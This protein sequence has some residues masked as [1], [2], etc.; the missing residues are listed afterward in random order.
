MSG[1]GVGRPLTRTW[2][3]VLLIS[4]SGVFVR[5]ADT[6]PAR[7]AFL[8]GFYALPILV[9]GALFL[10][11][12]AGRPLRGAVVPLAILAGGLLGA[13]LVAWHTSIGIIGAGLATVLPNLQVVLVGILGILLFR[14][15][16][17]ATFWVAV[18]VV[19]VG[20]AILGV[21]GHALTADASVL[22]GVLFGLLTAVF[23]SGYLILLRLA[24]LGRPEAGAFDVM[25]SATL[26]ASVVAGAWA[27][28][29][30]VAAPPPGLASNLWL[31]A[32]AVGSQV[33]G[34]V[35]LS[36]SIHRLPAALTSV[37]LLLQPVL[38]LVWGAGL[39]GE[40]I[41]PVDVLGAL[42]I[43]GGVA[44]AHRAVV[45]GAPPPEPAAPD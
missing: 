2:G 19:L 45:R 33:I 10:R 18:P 34:W 42:L 36:S 32:L 1:E 38:A 12:R 28:S 7:S 24:R 3:G 39:L 8:R 22:R 43:L 37:A 15:R 5:M 21:G 13:D 44:L 4:F 14:E 26:G 17:L 20:V 41:G 30:G 23:Y 40:P 35:L 6:E 9:V 29:Q 11:R 27:A 16:P 31:L 25:A